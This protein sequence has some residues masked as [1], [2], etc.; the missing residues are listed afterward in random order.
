MPARGPISPFVPAGQLGR[1]CLPLQ[2]GIL[3]WRGTADIR[4]QS[5]KFAGAMLPYCG[6]GP[7][8]T[9]L[10]AARGLTVGA[11]RQAAVCAAAGGGM[12]AMPAGGRSSA[13]YPAMLGF[14]PANGVAHSGGV[15][16]IPGANLVKGG[17][18]FA[19]G[20]MALAVGRR[21]D[22]GCP[23]MA[24]FLMVAVGSAGRNGKNKNKC[25]GQKQGT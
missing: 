25:G 11:K 13:V 17:F 20:A 14:Y 6:A 18:H 24:S 15:K 5:V 19:G 9:K 12:G 2:K 8:K 4:R 16:A 22:R 21:C 23:G 3:N 10:W 7:H 1:L